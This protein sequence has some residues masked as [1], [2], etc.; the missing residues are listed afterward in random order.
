MTETV[1]R[2]KSIKRLLRYYAN[3]GETSQWKWL[4][5]KLESERFY[6]GQKRLS[7]IKQKS[8]IFYCYSFYMIEKESS[9]RRQP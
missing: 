1:V 6:T 5:D 2:K 7:I 8:G 4:T 3:E 9:G